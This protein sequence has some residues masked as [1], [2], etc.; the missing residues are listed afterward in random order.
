M[1][2]VFSRKGF[3]SALG[4]CPSP[5][6]EPD[7]AMVSLPI[8]LA[9]ER[10]RFCDVRWEGTDLGEVVEDLSRGRVQADARTHLDPDLRRGAL[11]RKPGW[12][13]LFGQSGKAQA[14]LARHRVGPGD[15]FLFYGWFRRAARQDD[16]LGYVR[17][18]PDMHAV[19]GWL[20]VETVFPAA[21]GCP[22]GLAWAAGH[23]HFTLERSVESANNTVYLAAGRLQLPGEKCGD[24]PGAGAFA[25]FADDL[26][27]TAVAEG[28]A[29]PRSLWRLPKWFWSP[30]RDDRLSHHEDPDRW[31]RRR[32]HLLLRAASRGQEFVLDADRYREAL[33]WLHWLIRTGH[34]RT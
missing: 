11:P 32:D 17:D 22:P 20:Q 29:T 30:R 24:L 27:L 4:G 33:P 9:S 18:T 19:F 28:P 16:R 23:P 3:D 5:V 34:R 15:V 8:P 2:I 6:L 31:Q 21:Y 10:V 1:K 14:H 13:A 25:R 7:G 26:C 12:R